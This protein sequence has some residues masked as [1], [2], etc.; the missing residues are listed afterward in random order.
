MAAIRVFFPMQSI[1]GMGCLHGAGDTMFSALVGVICVLVIRNVIG[2]VC[3]I[4]LDWAFT[5]IMGIW[6]GLIA[7]HFTRTI[8]TAVRMHGKKWVKMNI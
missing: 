7:D 3:G 6:F 8:I 4:A 2:Y 1:I 5:G